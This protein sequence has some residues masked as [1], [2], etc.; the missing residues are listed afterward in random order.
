LNNFGSNAV[1]AIRKQVNAAASAARASTKQS[2]PLARL[3]HNQV[4]RIVLQAAGMWLAT[5]V[6][7]IVLTYLA[8]ALLLVSKQLDLS[9][10]FPGTPVFLQ[11]RDLLQ[12]LLQGRG[13]LANWVHADAS[14]YLLMG[15]HGYDGFTLGAASFFPLYPFAIHLGTLVIGAGQVL[16]VGLALSSLGALAAFIG[17]G[18]LGAHEQGDEESG[19]RLIMVVAAYPFAFYL[20]APFTEGFFLA[21]AVFALLFARTGRWWPAAICAFLAGLTRPTAIALILPLAWEFG[22]QHGYWERER[23]RAGARRALL[24]LRVLALGV[25]VIA[26]VPMAIAIFLAFLQL[27]YGSAFLYQQAQDTAH[28]HVTMQIWSTAKLILLRF[29][30][31]PNYEPGKLLFYIDAGSLI[32][33]GVLTLVGWR[34]LSFTYTLYSLT[35]LYLL[36]SVPIPREAQ[37][38]TSAARYMLA[39]IPVFLLLSSWL[40]RRPT[41]ETLVVGSGFFF[42]AV[43]VLAY[44][45]GVFIE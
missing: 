45:H 2:E 33:F 36:A 19:W 40:K 1:T 4:R 37:L 21:F 43:F 24:R 3:D 12:P 31:P 8:P 34:T 14:W 11:N 13:P 25:A 26:A 10:L 5:R 20:F 18:L 23:W 6:L 9:T 44:L 42:Q 38:I 39:A 35:T 30:H 17:L 32:V 22:R 27:R 29:L 41:L 16:I 15:V 7:F 28:G